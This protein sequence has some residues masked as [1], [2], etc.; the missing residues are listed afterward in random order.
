MIKKFENLHNWQTSDGEVYTQ[1]IE[2]RCKENNTASV[3]LALE[4]VLFFI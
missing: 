1:N 3:E 2:I 4:V